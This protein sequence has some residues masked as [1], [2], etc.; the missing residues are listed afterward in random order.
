M[1]PV[2]VVHRWSIG[3]AMMVCPECGS[4]SVRRSMRHGFLEWFLKRLFLLPYR[5]RACGPRFF[6]SSLL[7]Q[8]AVH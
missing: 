6:R 5:C 7:H 4:D 3:R 2:R 8:V 1:A